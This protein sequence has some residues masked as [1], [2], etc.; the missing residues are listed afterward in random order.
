MSEDIQQPADWSQQSAPP[1]RREQA[2]QSKPT[3]PTEPQ[4]TGSGARVRQGN[5]SRAVR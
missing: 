2:A 5:R 1:A 4:V 3:T